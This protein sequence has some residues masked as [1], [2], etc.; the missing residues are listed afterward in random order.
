MNEFR[1]IWNGTW[2][3]P[4]FRDNTDYRGL[5]RPE[6]QTEGLDEGLMDG[7][8]ASSIVSDRMSRSNPPE[9]EEEKGSK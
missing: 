2:E 1:V 9:I 7:M 6:E 5:L 4:E 3:D 8:R